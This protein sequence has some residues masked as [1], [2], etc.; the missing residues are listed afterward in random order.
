MNE[1]CG[2]C[3]AAPWK[4]INL[5]QFAILFVLTAIPVKSYIVHRYHGRKEKSVVLYIDNMRCL[6]QRMIAVVQNC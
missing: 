6:Y 1:G 5:F 2:V 3:I 4:V